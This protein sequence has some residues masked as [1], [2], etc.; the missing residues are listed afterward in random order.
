MKYPNAYKG[1]GKVFAAQILEAI[2]VIILIVGAALIVAG[3]SNGD[4]TAAGIAAILILAAGIV[5]IISYIFNLVGFIQAR[6]D[7][8]QFLVSV[9]FIIIAIVA[10][11]ISSATQGVNERL[12]DWLAFVALIFEIGVV[13]ASA[14]GIKSLA[15]NVGDTKVAKL[16][17]VLRIFLTILWVIVLVLR[18]FNNIQPDVGDILYLISGI[19]ELAAFV[20][21][22]VLLSKTRKMLAKAE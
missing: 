11:I 19:V 18:F 7:E 3:I 10:A 6:K 16:A 1:L 15:L 9:V 2:G 14:I 21:Y 4:L 13:E 12:S 17:D 5:V 20:V 22:I 8:K